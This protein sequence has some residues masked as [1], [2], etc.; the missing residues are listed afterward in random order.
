MTSAVILIT[1][2][3]TRTRVGAI[4]L[5]VWPPN[6]HWQKL[7]FSL[8]SLCLHPA[9]GYVKMP[10][11]QLASYMSLLGSLFGHSTRVCVRTLAF[12]N[13]HWPWWHYNF[14]VIR[15]MIFWGVQ[16]RISTKKYVMFHRGLPHTSSH[17]DVTG[18]LKTKRICCCTASWDCT[19]HTYP[20]LLLVECR[21]ECIQVLKTGWE[22]KTKKFTSFPCLVSPLVLMILVGARVSSQWFWK[23]RSL[24]LPVLANWGSLLSFQGTLP[25][26]T[27]M[28]AKTHRDN[29][30]VSLFVLAYYQK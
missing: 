1:E 3:H 7:A 29:S 10:F 6:T 26:A 13:L 18:R 17:A 28:N 19:R 16:N 15:V 12:S 21:M 14:L 11:L 30:H 9:Q 27:V 24:C 5:R 23:V 8:F 22:M 2:A 25:T 20:E 4:F